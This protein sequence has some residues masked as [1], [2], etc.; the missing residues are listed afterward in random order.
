MSSFIHGTNTSDI[1]LVSALT[2]MGVPCDENHATV[3]AGDVR[4]W[5]IGEVSN[6]GKYK[7][8]ELII[9][10]RDSQFHVRNPNHPFAYVKA[11]LW[12]HKMIVD[13]VKKDRKLVMIRKGDSIAF[14]HPDCSSD[15]E[16]KILTQFNQ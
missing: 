2:A 14:L 7:T 6:C 3:A 11:A 10:W 15:T 4:L 9:F 8:A 12:N 5:R 1:R 16:R 13:A